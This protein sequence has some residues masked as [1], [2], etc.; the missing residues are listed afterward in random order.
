MKRTI[1]LLSVVGLC[2]GL[3]NA[4][5]A[6]NVTPS[7]RA[8]VKAHNNAAPPADA[9]GEPG[10]NADKTSTPEAQPA[11]DK[12]AMSVDEPKPAKSDRDSAAV[13]KAKYNTAR[14][15]AQVVYNRAITKCNTLDGSAKAACMKN[16]K[17]AHADSLALA[18]SELESHIHMDGRPDRPTKSELDKPVAE[19]SNKQ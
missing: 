8:E 13:W 2:A 5:I 18:K 9:Q 12:P 16:A 15:K 19:A 6:Q 1:F 17:S 11:D 7:E 4:A 3:G 14:D 10:M